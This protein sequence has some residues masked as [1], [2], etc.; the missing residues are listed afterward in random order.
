MSRT[1]RILL[2][3]GGGLLGLMLVLLVAGIVIVIV[4][5]AVR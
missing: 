1:K 5:M 2:R 4:I 3:V